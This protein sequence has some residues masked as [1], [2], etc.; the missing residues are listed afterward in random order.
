VREFVEEVFGELG[1]D[2]KKHVEVDPRYFRPAEVEL[3]LG[4]PAKAQRILGWK[5]RITFKA[6]AQMMTQEDLKIAK[7][8]KILSQQK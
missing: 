5:P 8:E 3:L 7:K 6:L 4:D 2:Y 1:L